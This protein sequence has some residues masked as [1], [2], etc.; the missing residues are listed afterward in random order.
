MKLGCAGCLILIVVLT[1]LAALV[2]GFV[3]LS[4]NIFEEPHFEVLDWSRSDAS[5][6]RYSRTKSLKSVRR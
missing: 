3:F 4:S 2:G 1:F 6:A 5:A